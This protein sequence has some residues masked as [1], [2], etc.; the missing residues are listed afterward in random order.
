[1]NKFAQAL[2]YL[3]PTGYAWPRA[4]ESV[5]MRV[6]GGIAASFSEQDEF[7]S[8]TARQWLPHATNTRL[9]EWEDA[10]GLPD[11]CFGAIQTFEDRQARLVARLRG[12]QGHYTD[13]S[14]AAVGALEAV[15]ANL[16][17]AAE[18]RYNTPFRVGRDRVGRSLGQLDGQLYALVSTP[19]EPLRVGIGRVGSRLV[20]RQPG[21]AEM[22]CYLEKCAPARFQL[23]VIFV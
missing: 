8:N 9:P 17:Y 10:T 21:V 3:L 14:P 4:P 22:A 18:V 15:C 19:A 12:P 20:K 5:L 7:I 1:M 13:S 2:A 23:N 16:G 11:A 6:L